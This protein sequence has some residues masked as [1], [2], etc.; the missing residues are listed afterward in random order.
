VI[1]LFDGNNIMRRQYEQTSM[2]PVMSLRT[3]YEST[4]PSHIWVW[5]GHQHNER[6]RDIYP[7]YKTNR[8]PAPEN[9]YAQI[10]LWR[11]VLKNSPAIQ[12]EVSGWEAD[13]VISTIV[14]TRAQPVMIHTND[15]D[16]AQ[17][18]DLPHV[19][20][21]GV[22]TKGVPARWIPLYKAMQGDTSDNIKGIPGFG[23]KRWV[24]MEGYWPQIERAIVAGDPAGFLGLPFKPAVLAWL[25]NPD[26]V[27]ELQAMLSITYFENVP[28]D[29]LEG[30]II[31]GTPNRVVAHQM[32]SEYFL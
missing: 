7:A 16:Y 29:E 21:D 32:L 25:S 3:R 10:R 18:A 23:P 2:M 26:N 14:R 28:E 9:I 11:D 12:I 30:G 4:Q 22:N 17:L 13:D 15:M 24:E 6:R 5:D 20:L 8:T 19:K 31:I 27:K 1:H